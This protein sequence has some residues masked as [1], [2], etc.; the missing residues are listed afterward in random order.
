MQLTPS[1][2]LLRAPSAPYA[3][4]YEPNVYLVVDGKSALIIDGGLADEAAAKERLTYVKDLGVARVEQIVLTHHHRDHA[5]GAFLLAEALHAPVRMHGE[6]QRLLPEEVRR[7]HSRRFGPPLIADEALPVGRLRL[8]AIFT[9]GHSIGH[10]SFF[11][12]EESVLFSGDNVLGLGTTAIPPPP[13]GDMAVYIRS[14]ERMKALDARL[15]LPGHGP[16]VRE[17][18]RK[19]Q[20]LIDHRHEREEQ[21]LSLLR[22]GEMS[23]DAL[24]RR[25]YPELAPQLVRMAEGQVTAHLCKLRDEGKASLREKRGQLFASQPGS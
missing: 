20:E 16:P 17:P 9:P 10:L 25:L 3:G 19:I 11:L 1:V 21:L 24:V 7:Q 18:Q 12:E 5:G 14:L 6:E 13:A 23:V 4:P 2:H 15:I 22:E 8:R